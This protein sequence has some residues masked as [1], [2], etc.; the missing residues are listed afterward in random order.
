MDVGRVLRERRVANG[1][2]QARLARRA[3]TTQAA[4]SRIERGAVSPTTATLDRLL[5]VMGEELE[6]VV[7]RMQ[8]DFDKGH[9][10]DLRA[11][12][13]AERL[14]LAMTWNRLAGEVAEAGDRA[15]KAKP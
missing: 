13:P 11:R 1:L 10:D 3:G 4:I 12:P 2:S 7:R 6:V 9:L 8:G 14:E 15:R 5:S